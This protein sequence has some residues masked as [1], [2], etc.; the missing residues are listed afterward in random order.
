MRVE[1]A[2]RT[3]PEESID[4][5]DMSVGACLA[6]L[7]DKSISESVDDRVAFLKANGCPQS[8][9]DSVFANVDPY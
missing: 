4:L 2:G 9:I 5:S 3:P 8:V 6:V 7:V 1:L